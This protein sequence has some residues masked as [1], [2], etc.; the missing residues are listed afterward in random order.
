MK[1]WEQVRADLI[2][3]SQELQGQWEKLKKRS[4]S[5]WRAVR[6]AFGRAVGELERGLQRARSRLSDPEPRKTIWSLRDEKRNAV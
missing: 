6:H 3:Q 5:A 4:P 2:V 1:W